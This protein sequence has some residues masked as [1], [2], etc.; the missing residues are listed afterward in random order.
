MSG[1][2][3]YGSGGIRRL[4]S[5][6]W[7][8]EFRHSGQRWSSLCQTER[9]AERWLLRIRARA[10]TSG[11]DKPRQ[12]TVSG[13]LDFWIEQRSP[14]WRP[15]TLKTY[16]AMHEVVSACIGHQ[17]A[18]T[19]K[20][21]ALQKH[22]NDWQRSY[23]S[24]TVT[25]A[26]TVLRSAYREA[27]RK[28][29]LTTNPVDATD[30]PRH[31]PKERPSWTLV[32]AQ[33]FLR[34]SAADRY[35]A[36][37]LLMLAAGLRQGEARGLRWEDLDPQRQ[38]LIIR[39]TLSSDGRQVGPTKSGRQR[40]LYLSDELLAALHAHRVTQVAERLAAGAAW[41]DSGFIFTRERGA[42]LRDHQVRARFDRLQRELNATLSVAERLPRLS[43]HGL[44]HT[45]ASLLFGELGEQAKTIADTLG[46]ASVGITMDTYTHIGGAQR[47]ETIRR[48]TELLGGVRE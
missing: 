37:W 40:T 46:H 26:R 5:G 47:S 44:R 25:L 24:A 23:A 16:T 13:L 12:L 41:A 45:A 6:K 34:A 11:L 1:K 8:A 20:P 42:P 7:R 9:E 18:S 30:P 33:R 35:G 3:N 14:R 29:W 27:I 36:M 10:E 22:L 31:E 32:Q 21:A 48:M 15:A 43:P 17:Q 38:T 2:R 28:G 4:P 39:R 19:L